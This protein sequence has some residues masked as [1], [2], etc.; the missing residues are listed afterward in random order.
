MAEIIVSFPTAYAFHR[1]VMGLEYVSIL[2]FLAIFVILGIGVDDVFVFYDTYA[3]ATRA[4]GRDGDLTAR[5]SL[6]TER[7]GILEAEL[8]GKRGDA[9]E[10]DRLR[11]EIVALEAS[12]ADEVEE[13]E[14]RL[15]QLMASDRKEDEVRSL[16]VKIDEMAKTMGDT[17]GEMRQVE[18]SLR[19]KLRAAEADAVK[20]ERL[21]AA[22]EELEQRLADGE[23]TLA[24][25]KARLTAEAET[26]AAKAEAEAGELR[27]K[28]NAL[29]ETLES[30]DVALAEANTTVEALR[31]ANDDLDRRLLGIERDRD[32]AAIELAPEIVKLR[33][34]ASA[35][36][37]KLADA[38]EATKLA[39]EAEIGRASCRERV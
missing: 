16:R 17:L 7:V 38:D 14:R 19:A 35:Q 39:K 12:R 21:D 10:I 1:V 36:A 26:A 6:M 25:E 5:L 3:Q 20:G 28:L 31:K 8:E 33:A 23:A 32:A 9:D 37:A 2:Q 24:A 18:D 30:R 13:L 22:R 27:Q 15:S 11:E 29:K 34:E 4:V